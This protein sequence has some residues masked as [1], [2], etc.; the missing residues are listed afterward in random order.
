M[1]DFRIADVSFLESL[2]VE[3][4]LGIFASGYESRS[5][6][7]ARKLHGQ[8]DSK[9]LVFGFV[10]E[11]SGVKRKANDEYYKKKFGSKIIA[12]SG[13]DEEPIYRAID[14]VLERST[15]RLSILVDY[16]SMSRLWYT[17]ILNWARFR[18]YEQPIQID[19][20]YSPGRYEGKYRPMVISGWV[21][22]PGCEGRISRF[23]KSIAVF[24]L[25][26]HGDA[27]M[28]M[29]DRLEADN[30]YTV[31]AEPGSSR[32]IVT[33]TLKSNK[34][35]LESHKTAANLKF[36]LDS[37][38]ECFR[39]LAEI[40]APY[41]SHGNVTLVPMGPKPH[42]LASILLAMR[43]PEMACIRVNGTPDPSDV[44]PTG[45]VYVTR[46]IFEKPMDVADAASL[47]R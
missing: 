30:V 32:E 24:G 21:S 1:N 3:R 26:F 35:L 43:F 9:N 37:V 23:G 28:C 33:R 25:G 15:K 8:K 22:L 7:V 5:T 18:S 42:I 14:G 47:T 10:E 11:S 36:P 2:S 12:V 39:D 19:F 45:P 29:L 40:L 27:A 16:S 46:V 41:R 20:A 34:N 13:E 6:H 38:T 17:A 31:R 4:D 44:T